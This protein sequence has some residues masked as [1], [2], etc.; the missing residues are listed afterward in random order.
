MKGVVGGVTL[1]LGGGR[2]TLSSIPI[3]SAGGSVDGGEGWGGGWHD[4]GEG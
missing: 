4:G 2:G 3:S 1:P